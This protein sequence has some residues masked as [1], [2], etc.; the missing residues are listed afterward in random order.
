[1]YRAIV[2]LIWTMGTFAHYVR[3]NS[4]GKMG[5]FPEDFL[6]G[7][8]TSAYQT[9]GGWDADG[10]GLSMWDHFVRHNPDAIADRSNGDVAAKSYELYKR[11]V[12]MLTDLGVGS[13]RFSISW[14]RILP[15]GT[16]DYVNPMGVAYYNSLIDELLANGITPFVTMYHWD[17]PQALSERGGWLNAE[18]VDWFGNYSRVLYENFGD[19]VKFWLTINEPYIHCKVGYGIGEHAPGVR[20]PGQ[21]FYDCGRNI[22]MANARAYRAYDEF[23]GSQ[24][25]Q[26]G[27][28]FSL[29]WPEPASDSKD[30]LDAVSCYFAFHLGQ[31]ADPIFT[32][33]GN[34]PDILLERVETA[35]LKQGYTKSRLRRLTEE[36]ADY[37]KGTSDFFALNH[38]NIDIVYRN[39]SLQGMF[40]VPSVD[41]DGYFGYYT[42]NSISKSENR[43]LELWEYSPGF[44]KVLN[45]IN[46]KYNEPVIYVMENGK[47]TPKGLQ[48]HAKIEYLRNY[49][50]AMLGAIKSGVNI[51]GY[52]AWSLMDGFEWHMGYTMN[53]GLYEIDMT[54]ASRTRVPRTSAF[55]YKEIIRSG[56]VDYD[57]NPDPYEIN[58]SSASTA[59]RDITI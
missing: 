39:E 48:D 18:V 45:Y 58:K 50:T 1:M 4:S 43:T 7:V 6:F 24:G 13:Y 59:L 40:E 49:L 37:I 9:E 25:G 2:L 57:Y 12:E 14:P 30:D 33:R 17:L 16:S 15:Y 55:V 53:F 31:Y 10:K 8:A 44:Y 35:S 28:P 21:G 52:F 29:N 38:Y 23:R 5:R 47:N 56:M 36:E 22:L 27:L 32:E 11:D 3:D 54:D 41:D 51:K 46:E 26:V 42:K 19:R 34:Y 20:S